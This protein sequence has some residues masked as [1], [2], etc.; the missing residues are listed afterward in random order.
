MGL[1]GGQRRHIS[2]GVSEQGQDLGGRLSRQ[3]LGVGGQALGS[4]GGE[5]TSGE[6]D[7][8]SS[9]E[10]GHQVTRTTAPW[11]FDWGRAGSPGSS[12]LKC[13]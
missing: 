5:A 1:C 7:N 10:P 3:H 11:S 2:A 4:R 12:H 6:E 8:P 9:S 13:A